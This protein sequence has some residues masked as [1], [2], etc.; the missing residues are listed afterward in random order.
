MRKNEDVCHSWEGSKRIGVLVENPEWKMPLG[1]LRRRCEVDI[2]I[3]LKERGR[4][5]LT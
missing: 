3:G 1:R 5:I 4:E 2:K